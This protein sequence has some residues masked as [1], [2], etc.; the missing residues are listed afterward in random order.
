M[1]WG[2]DVKQVIDPSLLA[3]RVFERRQIADGYWGLSGQ[4]RGV[5]HRTVPNLSAAAETPIDL[6]VLKCDELRSA[7]SGRPEPALPE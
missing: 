2:N 6:G 5:F 4:L 3:D 7:R 1:I